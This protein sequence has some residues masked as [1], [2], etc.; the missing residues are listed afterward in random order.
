MGVLGLSGCAS[1]QETALP[2]PVS[3]PPTAPPPHPW[4]A[5]FSPA[6]A[7]ETSHHRRAWVILPRVG[8]HFQTEVKEVSRVGGTRKPYPVEFRNQMV[9]LVR[10]GRSPEQLAK[11][12]E[13]RRPRSGNGRIGRTVTRAVEVTV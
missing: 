3:P 8:G 11:E 12:F 5:A 6:S 13:P 10:A 4:R 1:I 9:E 7:L 2:Q